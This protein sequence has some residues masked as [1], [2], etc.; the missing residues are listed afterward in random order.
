MPLDD[1]SLFRE[2]SLKLEPIVKMPPLMPDST[3]AKTGGIPKK[4]E[5]Q[6]KEYLPNPKMDVHPTPQSVNNLPKRP[7]NLS[8][9]IWASEG[10]SHAQQSDTHHE[11]QSIV[12]NTAAQPMK[13]L[14]SPPAVNNTTKPIFEKA[15]A[16]LPSNQRLEHCVSTLDKGLINLEAMGEPEFTLTDSSEE[17]LIELEP[18]VAKA[19]KTKGRGK[20]S[21]E[22]A[23]FFSSERE[24]SGESVSGKEVGGREVEE[25]KLGKEEVSEKEFGQREALSPIMSDCASMLS[26]QDAASHA[27]H[28]N[29]VTRLHIMGLKE[30]PKGELSY[31][32]SNGMA[33]SE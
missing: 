4:P 10:G 11:K 8:S 19:F 26:L 28:P 15:P 20:F 33:G 14:T 6:S 27:L 5:N 29:F 2:Y 3:S 22:L 1:I 21:T 23:G 30:K 13:S 7:K 31:R 17:D 16:S 12:S 24:F 25:R 32:K 9:S 18:K